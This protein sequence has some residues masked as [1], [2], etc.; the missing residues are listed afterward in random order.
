MPA[1]V[2]QPSETVTGLSLDCPAGQRHL[3]AMT[4]ARARRRSRLDLVEPL[5]DDQAP[6]DARQ[7][8]PQEGAPVVEAPREALVD[9][10]RIV[11]D[12]Q[13]EIVLR[14]GKASITLRR[15]GRIIIRGTR[16]ETAAEGVNRI[17]GGTVE[18]N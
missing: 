16:V 17:K 14:C 4:N 13:D 7:R 2:A 10:R 11:F 9:G 8:S 15:N 6:G 3:W 12:A 5:P 1:A 18:I